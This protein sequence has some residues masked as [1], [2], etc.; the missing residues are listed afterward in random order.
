MKCTAHPNVETGLTCGKCGTPICPKCLVHTPV[1]ARCKEC[2]GLKRL[3]TYQVA[4]TQYLKAAVVGLAL[5][6][7]L[8]IAWGWL[9]GS[10]PYFGIFGIFVA[11]GAGYLIGEAITRSVNR[12]RGTI[13]QVIGG[14]SFVLTYAVSNVEYS[15]ET[16][17]AFYFSPYGIL[18]LVV[19]VVVAVGRL[20]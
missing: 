16:G 17:P 11:A 12:R 19:G 18:A 8:G 3:P 14:I 6:L 13:L 7:A 9:R 20:R 10:V 1:G 15:S 5:A 4:T 2:A